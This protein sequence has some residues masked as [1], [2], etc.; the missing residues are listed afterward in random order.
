M[1]T[2]TGQGRLRSVAGG[3]DTISALRHAG[4]LD[5]L[6]YVSTAGGAFLEWLEGK[7]LPGSPLWGEPEICMP[8]IAPG[9]SPGSACHAA[10][11]RSRAERRLDTEV[12][13]QSTFRKQACDVPHLAPGARF[14]LAVKVRIEPR[15]GEDLRPQRG[16]HRTNQVL[17]YRIGM[18]DCRRQGQAGDRTDMLL[19]LA[20]QAG[21]DRPVSRVVRPGRELVGQHPPAA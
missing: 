11:W 13:G 2:A 5:K 18:S 6:S 10:T 16:L 9:L 8:A 20:R 14:D 3:G 7:T 17:H 15:R 1:A 12:A 19:E 4:V 21:V